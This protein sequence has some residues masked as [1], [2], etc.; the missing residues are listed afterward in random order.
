MT[1]QPK[2]LGG[3]K[4]RETG[5]GQ[6]VVQDD[7]FMRLKFYV[8]SRNQNTSET[9]HAHGTPIGPGDTAV[10]ERV[11]PP[12]SYSLVSKYHSHM[13]QRQSLGIVRASRGEADLFRKDREASPRRRGPAESQR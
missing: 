2:D 9:Y 4:E 6:N 11:K 13:Q 3:K 12:I 7:Q 5:R 1:Y 10:N 8:H